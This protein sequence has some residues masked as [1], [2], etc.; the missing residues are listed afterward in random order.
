MGSS[1]STSETQF[2]NVMNGTPAQFQTDET[3]H[4]PRTLYDDANHGRPRGLS[5]P[6]S[7]EA[8]SIAGTKR[9]RPWPDGQFVPINSPGAVGLPWL[10]QPTDPR[11]G[12]GGYFQSPDSAPSLTPVNSHSD[13]SGRG[14]RSSGTDSRPPSLK[15]EPSST[16]SMS[17]HGSYN[18]P[19]TPSDA[20]LPIHALLSSKPDSYPQPNPPVLNHPG[21]KATPPMFQPHPSRPP[22]DPS[23][24]GGFMMPATSG[25]PRG[26]PSSFRSVE[27]PFLPP[28]FAKE[29]H[30]SP[31]IEPR[32]PIGMARPANPA[33]SNL[34]GISALLKAKEIV[35]RR[36]H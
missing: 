1:V 25:D 13:S 16:G 21:T 11:F 14:S 22:G 17:S 9:P 8:P 36:P 31:P 7:A 34:D 35:D 27:Q 18:L 24:N 2:P 30:F 20:S 10:N 28:G 23:I 32:A 6:N 5:S 4:S 29:Q 15:T 12:S 33:E 26:P 3:M 19:R